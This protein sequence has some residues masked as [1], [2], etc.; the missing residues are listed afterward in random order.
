LAYLTQNT[1]LANLQAADSQHARNVYAKLVRRDEKLNE[2][3]I[4]LYDPSSRLFVASDDPRPEDREYNLR[5]DRMNLMYGVTTINEL[6]TRDGLQPVPW[7][8]EPYKPRINDSN[9]EKEE[10]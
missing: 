5:R 1:N 2:Q 3:F 4:P 6:R 10:T 8:N 9:A 7:G